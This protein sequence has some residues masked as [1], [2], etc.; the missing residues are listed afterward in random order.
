MNVKKLL[1]ALLALAMV[2]S[3][4]ALAETD[5]LQAQLE[6][7][8]AR[9]AELEAQVELYKPYYDNQIVAEYGDGKIVWRDDAMKEYEA[10]ASAYAQYGMN[11]DDYADQIKQSILESLTQ[12][13]VLADKAAE[14]GLDQVDEETLA[15]LREEAQKT[16]DNYVDR[17][18][19]NYRDSFDAQ[20]LSEEE[21]RQQIIQSLEASGLTLDV[22]TQQMVDSYV[23]EQLHNKVTEDVEVSDEEVRAK[24]DAMVADDQEHYTSDTSYNSDRNSGATIA[25]NPEGYRAVKHVLIKFDDEQEA[26]YS[27]LQSTLTSLNDELAALDAPAEASEEDAEASEEDAE[28]TEA[29][30]PTPEPR[31][32]EQIQA[33]IGKVAAEIEALYSQLLPKAQEVID[34][35]NGGADFE[36]LIEQYNEDPGMTQEPTATVGYA[37][38]A[39]ST[40]WDPAFT[41]G[42]MS[43]EAVG[44]I[45][46]PVYGQ[47]GIHVIWYMDD[48]PAG[49]VPFEDI[50]D[51]VKEEALSDK[52]SQTYDDQVQAWME[53]AAPVYHLDRF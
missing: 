25:W 13:A 50:A 32:R 11:I 43:I 37:V 19:E 15:G 14:L 12:S 21:G 16:F 22:L 26:N 52:I 27:D 20:G 39:D 45:S 38:S 31:S 9:I 41:E 48:I 49:A 44:Q 8:N 53:E 46:E 29:P 42:A 18:V 7:A 2:L 23:D 35:F 1:C 5:D 34:A 30:Q 51:A 10:A 24:Y 4:A 6:A 3:A 47:N 33:D 40:V 28:A 17:Y 36:S